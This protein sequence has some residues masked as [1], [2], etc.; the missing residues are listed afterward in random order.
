MNKKV[1]LLLSA[2]KRYSFLEFI[3]MINYEIYL[4][5]KGSLKNVYSQEGEDEFLLNSFKK[6]RI[7]IKDIVYLDIGAA[8]P[9]RF[10][11]TYA[12]Y[13]RG[14][15]GVCVDPILDKNLFKAKRPKD[16]AVQT[17]VSNKEENIVFYEMNP[18]NNSTL[19]KEEALKRS[20]QFGSIIVSEKKVPSKTI[21]TILTEYAFIFKDKIFGFISIDVEGLDSLVLKTMSLDSNLLPKYIVIEYD[22]N[23]KSDI[24]EYLNNKYEL[25]LDTPINLVFKLK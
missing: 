14:A 2:F 20:K 4:L 7:N 9:V 8:E 6:D 16:I 19:S 18:S 1:T 22:L 25:V 24:L 12:F 23:Q 13:Q 5:A 17:A 15:N 10:S 3:R 11:N 21:D